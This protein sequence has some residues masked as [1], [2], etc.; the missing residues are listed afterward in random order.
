M[1]D[2]YLF[3]ADAGVSEDERTRVFRE[4][5]DAFT[6]LDEEQF[7]A[8]FRLCKDAARE[9]CDAVA[10]DLQRRMYCSL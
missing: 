4:H 9:V 8:K 10:G 7:I 3:L 2:L 1:A 6:A 5:R